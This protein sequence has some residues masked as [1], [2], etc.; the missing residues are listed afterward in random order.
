MKS[1]SKKATNDALRNQYVDKLIEA[2]SRMDEDVLRVGSNELA[3]PVVDAEGE[4]SYVVFTVKVPTGSRDGEVYDAYDLAQEY[5]MKTKEK[6]EKAKKAAEEKA[7]KI[8]RD[9]A[10]RKQK[11]EAK[12]RANTQV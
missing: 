6:A 12:A 8:A 7:R 2:L 9:E 5:E 4:D 10:M 11:A 1:M 3:I